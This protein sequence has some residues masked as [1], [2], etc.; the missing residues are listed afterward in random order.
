M[1][2]FALLKVVLVILL[3]AAN[4]FFVAAEFALVSVRDT[5]IQQLVEMR[6]IGAR[7]V[8]RLHQNLDE[9]LSAVQFGITLASI[10]LGWVGEPTI[11]AM[12]ERLLVGVPYATQYAHVIGFAV[13][14][15]IIT[16]LHVIL[17]EV[18]PKSLAL[19][20]AERMALAVAAPMDVFMRISRPAL[21][22][23]NKG[24]SLVLRLFGSRPVREGGVHSPDELKLIVTASSRVGL[25]PPFQEDMIHRALEL[26]NVLVREIMVPRTK[27][28]SL[29]SDMPIEEAMKRVVEEQHSRV[30]VYDAM[31]GPEFIVGLL[32]SKD[33]ARFMHYQLTA[34]ESAAA[35]MKLTVSNVMR[36]VLVVPETKPVS[37]LLEEF[38]TRKRHL[39]VVVDEFGSTA[40]VVTVE[41]ALEQIVG[42]LED[43]FDIAE[44]RPLLMPGGAAVLDGSES[45][46]DLEARYHLILPR[47]EGFE[48]LAGFILYKLGRIPNGGETVDHDG[49]RFTVLSMNGHR[50]AKVKVEEVVGK[51][52]E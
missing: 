9:V 13:A 6:R 49:H 18:V 47:D 48:T 15:G 52:Q 50:I 22:F 7:T 8:Q 32:Y 10:A 12:I 43:E 5:R 17:G 14:F 24:A 35:A 46:L 31:R 37:D 23:M 38:K 28:F 21:F 30:P 34:P 44:R 33:L 36:D 11:A 16:V 25:L 26:G 1:F 19:Q 42:E 27:I 51:F 2:T 3:V 20:R 40:G 41:D 4:A 45:I 39:A 29:P